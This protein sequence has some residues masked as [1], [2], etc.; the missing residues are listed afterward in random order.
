MVALTTLTGLRVGELLALRWRAVELDPGTI[1][2]SE[3]LFQGQFPETQ[4]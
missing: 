4:E 1:R 2:V 3:S